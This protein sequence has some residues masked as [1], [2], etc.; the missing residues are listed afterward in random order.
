VADSAYRCANCRNIAVS[1]KLTHEAAAWAERATDASDDKL[2]LAHPMQRCIGEHRIKF[3]DE[4]ERMSVNLADS[5]PLH[6]RNREQLVAQIDAKDVGAGSLDLRRQRAIAAAEIQDAL[7]RPWRK[8]G[9]YGA[10]KLLN[11]APVP[12]VV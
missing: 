10:S 6:A 11:E 3:R 8:H 5:E 9:E 1:A 7:A 2:G 12:R 4:V